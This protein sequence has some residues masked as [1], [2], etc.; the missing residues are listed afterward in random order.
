MGRGGSDR[1]MPGVSGRF[2]QPLDSKCPQWILRKDRL[3][4]GGEEVEGKLLSPLSCWPQETPRTKGCPACPSQGPRKEAAG[5]PHRGSPWWGRLLCAGTYQIKP[6]R[7]G[8]WWQEP[9]PWD[10]Q[11]GAGVGWTGHFAAV[12]LGGRVG[13]FCPEAQFLGQSGW[14]LA[15]HL[16]T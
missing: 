7:L 4:G 2:Q 8:V 13:T 5:A 1:R 11:D 15:E 14:P 10:G 3:A 16:G 12:M 6:A 9:G